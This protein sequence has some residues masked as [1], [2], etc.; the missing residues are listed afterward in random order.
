MALSD[1]L[2]PHSLH[3]PQAAALGVAAPPG[4]RPPGRAAAGR[5]RAA[6]QGDAGA[7]F[8]AIA[9][10]ELNGGAAERVTLTFATREDAARAVAILQR[11]ADARA[12]A[13]AMTETPARR[14]LEAIL[15]T[16]RAAGED[17]VDWHGAA[18]TPAARFAGPRRVTRSEAAI[19]DALSPAERGDLAAIK[20]AAFE[21][22]DRHYP[23]PAGADEEW[24]RNDGHNDA[25]RRAY[26]S[27]LMA[28][29]FGAA[30]AARF[31]AA[32]AAM[33][34]SSPEGTAMDLYNNEIGRRIAQAHP[35][36]SRRTL[37]EMVRR[38]IEQGDML[39]VGRGGGLAWSD[40]VAYGAH[41]A[42][43]DAAPPEAAD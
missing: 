9:A 18:A 4:T 25:F 42:A 38:A 17:A 14:P 36:A 3:D 40:R 33:P 30:F 37:A 32:H 11:L 26:W 31:A 28:R 23:V 7:P 20:E 8:P 2:R 10:L 34:G 24:A 13:A 22:A 43:G 5:R 27:A 39:V 41:G 16:Y 6:L 1:Q 15:E 12:A 29:R 19:L 21:A 35:D